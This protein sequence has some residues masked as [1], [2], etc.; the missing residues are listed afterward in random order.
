MD[1]I[2]FSFTTAFMGFFAIM[3]PIANVPVFLSLTSDESEATTR[4]IALR[5]VVLAFIIVTF[6]ALAGKIIFSLSVFQSRIC[7]PR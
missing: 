1:G 5:A 7:P 3:N 6:F 4:R 2:L